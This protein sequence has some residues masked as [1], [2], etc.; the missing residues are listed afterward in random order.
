MRQRL[1][2]ATAIVHQPEL[3]FLDEPTSGVDPKARRLFWDLIY[4]LVERGIT[5]IVTTH[6]MD[7]AEYCKRVGIM[8][9]GQLL[10]YDKPSKLKESIM[11]GS[12]WD[13]KLDQAEVGSMNESIPVLISTL[14][15]LQ[16]NAHVIRA[17]LVSDHL[18]VVTPAG[19]SERELQNLLPDFLQSVVL[20]NRVSPTLEDVFLALASSSGESRKNVL[21]D[22]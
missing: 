5:A 6:Y 3:L 9:N 4:E 7:E 21:S 13:I 18:R 10:A 22:G 12:T 19:T 1:A 15:S 11:P 16:K 2:L 8:K 17:S 14:G 20:L